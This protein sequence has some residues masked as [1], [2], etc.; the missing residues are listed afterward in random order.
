MWL[1]ICYVNNKNILCCR[2][3]R[4]VDFIEKEIRYL[5]YAYCMDSFRRYLIS[6]WSAHVF[7]FLFT[8]AIKL[9]SHCF[10][11]SREL[12]QYFSMFLLLW[13][14]GPF[15]GLDRFFSSL[16]L[17]TAG[18]SVNHKATTYTQDNINRMTHRDIHD[19]SRIR[20]TTTMFEGQ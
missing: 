17:Y 9:N 20:T 10:L 15:L 4:N 6:V 7:N 19:S 2:I 5:D 11:W 1:Q 14:Y 3:E 13:L 12:S 18:W 8:V 16:M